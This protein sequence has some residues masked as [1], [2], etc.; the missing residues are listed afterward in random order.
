MIKKILAFFKK[1]PRIDYLFFFF[2]GLVSLTWFQGDHFLSGGCFTWH[3]DFKEY[4][5][6]T[7]YMWEGIVSTG[8]SAVRTVPLFFPYA[9][10]GRIFQFFF[11]DSLVYEK[12]LFY[13]SFSV[14]GASAYYLLKTLGLKRLPCFAGSLLYMLNPFASVIVWFLSIGL[15]FPYYSFL[16][17]AV[18]LFVKVMRGEMGVIL[19]NILL[20]LSPMSITYSSPVMF[21]IPCF[22]FLF[23]FLAVYF[24][25]FL[26]KNHNLF[27][28]KLMV[29]L[30]FFLLF[31]LFNLYWIIPFVVDFNNQY[32]EASNVA[33]GLQEDLPTIRLNSLK[34]TDIFRLL[35]LWSFNQTEGGD[36]Y[37]PWHKIFF[38]PLFTLLSFLMG[39]T[40]LLGGFS[41]VAKKKK[42]LLVWPLIMV[43][44]ILMISG[45]YLPVSTLLTFLYENFPYFLRAFRGGFTK[46]GF[47]YIIPYTI[48]FSY[49]LE[50]LKEKI[51]KKA[52][53][54]LIVVFLLG[55]PIISGKVI[56]KGGDY[57]RSYLVKIPPY[58][59]EFKDWDLKDDSTFR[60]LVLPIPKA[61]T[62]T[63][64]W[65]NGYQGGDY[66]KQY[67]NKSLINTHHPE[68]V[69]ILAEEI[70]RNNY[71]AA[72]R[73][74]SLLNVKKIIY[75]EDYHWLAANSLLTPEK[76]R[77]ESFL[78]NYEL[79]EEMG[80][81][82]IYESKDLVFLPRIYSPGTITYFSS[83]IQKFLFDFQTKQGEI[84]K[85]AILFN[86][87]VPEDK[88]IIFV[89][90]QKFPNTEEIRESFR[91]KVSYPY[92]KHKPE[93]IMYRLMLCKE[94]L[95]ELLISANPVK[96]FER[97]L[98]YAN[99]R[100][101][102]SLKFKLDTSGQYKEKILESIAL[103]ENTD[104]IQLRNYL[105]LRLTRSIDDNLERINK[106]SH[107]KNSYY[108]VI[109]S[110]INEL[111]Q[112]NL[113][114]SLSERVLK[115]ETEM[116]FTGD[117][118][119]VLDNL[120]SNLR[121]EDLEITMDGKVL[122]ASVDK[123]GSNR[124]LTD[125]REVKGGIHEVLVK[126]QGL[127]EKVLT[128]QEV[129]QQAGG[130]EE[131]ACKI[132]K[133]QQSKKQYYIVND[134]EEDS[135]YLL[136]FEYRIKSGGINFEVVEKN[137]GLL[138]KVVLDGDIDSE[139]V[140]PNTYWRKS[141]LIFISG[142]TPAEAIVNF[143]QFSDLDTKPDVEIRNV[144]L[145]L[146]PKRPAV[147]F[148]PG[149][150][151]KI[152]VEKTP[153]ITFERINPTKYK[154]KVGKVSS[155]YTLVLLESFHPAW[156]VYLDEDN[157]NFWGRLIKTPLAEDRHFR[158][159]S[160]ANAWSILP[161]DFLGKESYELIIEF[162]YQKVFYVSLLA[163]LLTLL[164]SITLLLIKAVN[165]RRKGRK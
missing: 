14:S 73:I 129:T 51:G 84:N 29:F 93:T 30:K 45:F 101:E 23:Y 140:G 103:V 47:V 76:E 15:F 150:Y 61:D 117:Y 124:F 57:L 96:L 37:Y 133:L 36:L 100:I 90:K 1:N 160:Y 68:L 34:F 58:Y 144:S 11:K 40:V 141:Q 19:A 54:A 50:F 53:A 158:V 159:N 55:F 17:L 111:K 8:Y 63:L 125:L 104:N 32:N 43:L 13:L 85:E 64:K 24:P 136:S 28:E 147:Y 105:S 87:D 162:N 25:K 33:I 98:Y 9:V 52:A 80:S 156:K 152:T 165:K 134:W 132:E 114:F 79:K 2:L 110:L 69:K 107:H 22:I 70:N 155:P 27:K 18:A 123:R 108:A 142:S 56:F 154:V 148:Y 48:L 92:V 89:S 161:E 3:V 126:T 77:I 74:L 20:F 12:S 118:Y 59:S 102:E 95:N 75:R 116:P 138:D 86:V 16:P 97:K 35:G 121:P 66:L 130:D 164:G 146:I 88:D 65:E 139:H 82:K 71:R 115:Y 127:K 72:N 42:E 163:S 62:L 109:E 94:S 26:D 6:T 81:L 39:A 113:W 21:T 157:G 60:Y 149:S 106:L 119:L 143:C 112:K 145:E 128:S 122:E 135:Y 46:Y 78:K 99:K 41:I 49:G 44:G 131:E 83:S 137:Q 151:E 120:S 4:L 5:K 7:F 10:Y 31:I 91:E 38:S 67:S 153:D